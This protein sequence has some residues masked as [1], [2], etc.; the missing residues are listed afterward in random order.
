[1]DDERYVL[2]GR[3]VQSGEPEQ[4]PISAEQFER[5]IVLAEGLP[6]PNDV[7]EGEDDG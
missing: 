1:M 3:N 2:R 7:A 6:D 4:L 5:V